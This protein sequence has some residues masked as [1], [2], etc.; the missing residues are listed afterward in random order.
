[1]GQFLSSLIKDSKGTDFAA[2]A[3]TV[4]RFRSGEQRHG[5]HQRYVNMRTLLIILCFTLVG[6]T[7]QPKQVTR[8]DRSDGVDKHEASVIAADYLRQHMAASFGHIGPF[9]GGTL[10]TFKITG[11]VVPVELS[12]IPPLLVDKGTGAV[13]WEAKPPLK[14]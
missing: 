6:C 13:T 4:L 11:D 2:N 14:R 10:W 1:M 9:D 5:G 8:V 7:S 12:D 3:G